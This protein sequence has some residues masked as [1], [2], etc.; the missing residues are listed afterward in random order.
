MR[1]GG[2][3]AVKVVEA[4]LQA[5]LKPHAAGIEPDEGWCGVRHGLT[6]VWV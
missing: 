2:I 3:G 4:G 6:N 1:K 5:G